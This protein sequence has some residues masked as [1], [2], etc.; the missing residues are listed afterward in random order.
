MRTSR[1]G[2]ARGPKGTPD[3]PRAI[4]HTEGTV[5]PASGAARSRSVADPGEP[6]QQGREQSRDRVPEPDGGGALAVGGGVELAAVREVAL[7]VSL[8]LA[9]QAL[10]VEHGADLVVDA[11]AADVDVRRA[12]RADLGVDA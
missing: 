9:C 8:E 1:H 5:R 2:L 7:E 3:A 10:A 4:R 11:E 6:S 12:D